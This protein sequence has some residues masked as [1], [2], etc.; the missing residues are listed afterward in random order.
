M[1]CRDER[2][3]QIKGKVG[4]L[5]I[6]KLNNTKNGQFIILDE[7]SRINFELVYQLIIQ[8]QEKDLELDLAKSFSLLP[9]ILDED[10]L[11]TL[12]LKKIIKN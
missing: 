7:T 12:L 9:E 1:L 2:E 8:I 10:S 11:I 3:P 4:K 6:E 5:E